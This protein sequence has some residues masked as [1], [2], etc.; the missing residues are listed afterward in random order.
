MLSA[1]HPWSSL[2]AE[3]PDGLTCFVFYDEAVVIKSVSQPCPFAVPVAELGRRCK[4]SKRVD[5][6]FWWQCPS[7]TYVASYEVEDACPAVVVGC[8]PGLVESSTEALG[9]AECFSFGAAE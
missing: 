6:Q 3:F 7:C 4:S 9:V 5:D 1:T 8:N 2:Q